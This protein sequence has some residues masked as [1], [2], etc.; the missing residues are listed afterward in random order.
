MQNQKLE[1]F[2]IIILYPFFAFSACSKIKFVQQLHW[3]L[4][5]EAD[6]DF[7][8]SVAKDRALVNSV[9]S[10]GWQQLPKNS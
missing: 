8:Q 3:I 5:E 4:Y 9:V 1:N 2:L 7:T 6:G 10:G